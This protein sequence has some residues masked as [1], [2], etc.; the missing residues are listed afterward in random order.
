MKPIIKEPIATLQR[1]LYWTGGQPFLTQKLCQLVTQVA[2][3]TPSE[4]LQISP[5][6][7]DFWVDA[8]VKTYVLDNWEAQDEPVHLRTI[9]DRLFWNEARTGR[10]LSIYQQLL[11]GESVSL[12]DSRE[13]IELR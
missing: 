12:D 7:E 5:G 4:T 10:M 13:Q 2:Y 6:M 11:H 3:Q 8:L 1:I 9:R